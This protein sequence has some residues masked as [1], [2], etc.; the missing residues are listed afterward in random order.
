MDEAKREEGKAGEETRI[1]W[2]WQCFQCGVQSLGAT[3]GKPMK[4]WRCSTEMLHPTEE[5]WRSG[6]KQEISP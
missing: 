6:F 1:E 4:C 3:D 5:Q 2:A